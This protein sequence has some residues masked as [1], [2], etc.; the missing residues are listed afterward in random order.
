MGR[1]LRRMRTP[2][3][4][5]Q[6]EKASSVSGLSSDGKEAQKEPERSQSL[7]VPKRNLRKKN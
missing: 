5:S 2:M 4:E 6:K 3:V 7:P 1:R